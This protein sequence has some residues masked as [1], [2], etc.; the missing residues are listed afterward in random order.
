MATRKPPTASSQSGGFS[1]ANVAPVS[2]ARSMVATA[3]AAVAA[4]AR[5]VTGFSTRVMGARGGR[6]AVAD[7]AVGASG[8]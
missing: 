5:D 8:S 2:Q 3:P 7:P 4:K 1:G 6:P